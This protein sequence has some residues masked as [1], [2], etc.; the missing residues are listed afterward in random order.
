M[1]E[2]MEKSSRRLAKASASKP[3]PPQPIAA[4]EDHTQEALDEALCETFPASDPIAVDIAKP[5]VVDTSGK[6]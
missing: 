1:K 6:T 5:V 4:G 2:T 3:P